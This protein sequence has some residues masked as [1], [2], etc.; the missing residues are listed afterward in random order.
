MVDEVGVEGL[1]M[2]GLGARLG[3]EAMSLYNHVPNKAALLD[4]LVEL[5]VLQVDVASRPDEAW[6]DTLRRIALEYRRLASAH[7]RV[8]VLLATRPLSTAASVAHV[9]PLYEA[10]GD[11]GYSIPD[12]M[13]MLN[14]FFTFLNG[15]LL[16]EVGTVPGHAD[17]PEPRN[18]SA[19][20]SEMGAIPVESLLLGP[21][22]GRAVEILI[23]GLQT[24]PRG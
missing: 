14:T 1:S 12:R 8:F 9:A 18:E 5:L 4:G 10:L 13:L 24:V 19:L 20:V 16:A 11:S 23:A 17:V 3:V 21:N 15:Y 22:F 6:P 2:R 7:A